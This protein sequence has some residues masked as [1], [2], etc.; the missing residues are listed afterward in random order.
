M[1]GLAGKVFVVSGASGG[2]GLATARRL[3]EEGAHVV[4]LDT[5][6]ASADGVEAL[7]CDVRNEAEVADCFARISQKHQR[8]NGIVSNAAVYFR[9][10]E[11]QIHELSF[12]TW[13]DTLD[14][15]LTGAFFF[16]KHGV[17][18][19]RAGGKGSV[20]VVGSPNGQYGCNPGS[21]AYSTSKAGLYGMARLMAIDYA[22]DGIRVNLVLP[23]YIPTGLN[24]SMTSN[25]AVHEATMA[26]LPTGTA[27]TPDE[28]AASIAFLLSDD[29]AYI[30]GA[31]LY[32]D[33]GLTAQ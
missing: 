31:G 30:T 15:N 32:V 13:R 27:G 23:G 7:R 3:L 25:K 12:E 6:E 26:M 11:A 29:A 22:R 5:R 10:R 1:R 2:I 14:V 24:T 16:C 4:S 33:G 21:I 19:L 17:R 20:V 9:E 28:V 18:A 8:I